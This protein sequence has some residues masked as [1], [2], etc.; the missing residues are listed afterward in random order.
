[1]LYLFCL[2]LYIFGAIGSRVMNRLSAI[3][4]VIYLGQNNQILTLSVVLEK[5]LMSGCWAAGNY[6][7]DEWRDDALVV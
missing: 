1:M 3:L 2:K 6:R 4:G 7:R 5:P